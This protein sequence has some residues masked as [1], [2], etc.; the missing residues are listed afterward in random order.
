V[1]DKKASPIF[2]VAVHLI[3]IRYSCTLLENA[4]VEG[5]QAMQYNI[6][7]IIEVEDNKPQV[8]VREIG[9]QCDI[10]TGVALDDATMRIRALL[11]RWR[12][13]VV[14]LGG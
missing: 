2:C 1:I 12:D 5:V 4:I 9:E 11:E 6:S 7:V 8:T 13:E 3:D 14:R 10:C